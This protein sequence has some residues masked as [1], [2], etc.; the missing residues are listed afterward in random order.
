MTAADGGRLASA[1]ADR[2]Q[3]ERE[4]GAGGMATVYLAHDP[5]H[6]RRVAVKVLH[7]ELAAVIGTER[8][9]AEIRT[10]ATLH[11]PHILGLI[12]SGQ[13]DGI[14]YYVMPFVEGESLRDRLTREKQ[15]PIDDALRLAREVADALAYAHGRGV[16]HRDIKP[17]NILLQDGH[18][19]VAD[20]GIAL[21]IAGAGA[22]RLTQT[23]LSLGTPQYM[24]PEQAMGEKTVDARADVY[25]LGAVLYEMLT[26]EPPFAGPT[27]QAIVAKV[28]T[29]RPAA[30][31]T[32]RERVPPHVED[33]VLRSLEK[34]PADRFTSASELAAALVRGDADGTVRRSHA[35]A[36][37]DAHR[38]DRRLTIALV[39][40]CVV[41]TAAAIAGW[42]RHPQRTAL[43]AI[44]FAIPLTADGAA[45]TPVVYGPRLA[46]SPDGQR[47][48]FVGPSAVERQIYVRAL[49]DAVPRALAGT[50]GAYQLAFSP[51]GT[52]LAFVVGDLIRRIEL[53]NGRVSTVCTLPR[54]NELTDGV[55]WGDDDSLVVI[56]GRRA[57]VLR[58]AA[59]GGPPTVLRLA[60]DTTPA[61]QPVLLFWPD[62]LPGGKDALVNVNDGSVKLQLLSLRTGERTDLLPGNVFARFAAPGHLLVQNED[63]SVSAI[64][65]DL[66]T[67]R[68]TGA[69][70]VVLPTVGQTVG[71]APDFAVS[72]NGVFAF[73]PGG[74]PRRTVVAVE[75]GG[76]VS[77]LIGK[78]GPYDDAKYSPDG[79]RIVLG[80]GVGNRRDLWVYD[81]ARATKTRL[82]FESDN[83]FPVWNPDGRTIAFTSRRAGPA[84]IFI[85]S[86]DGTPAVRP[87]VNTN[88]LSFTGSF[89]A[90]GRTLY[91]RRTDPTLGFDIF[92]VGVNDT[93]N[94]QRPVLQ[95]RFN[96]S[97]PA[98]SPNGQLLA[99]VS[100]ESGRSEIYVRRI[101]G[102]EQRWLVT[103]DGGTEPLWRRDGKELFFRRGPDV[104]AVAM[105]GGATPRFGT[106]VKL[107]SGSYVGNSRTT[108]FD[109]SP[110]G[111][112]FLMIRTERADEHIEVTTDWTAL[113]QPRDGGAPR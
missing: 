75:R 82:T 87:V 4:L 32:R 6:G 86:A 34:L 113:L 29:E 54:G 105:E 30:I 41:A 36:G 85:V 72:R 90:D 77:V 31:V 39:T 51:D 35:R 97:A 17:E 13:V 112:R 18:A 12:D 49:G 98:V 44:R 28:L 78:E 62:L 50:E 27:A 61:G 42:L 19:L 37:V 109:V 93:A 94:L 63:L 111:T 107:F 24:A 52:S 22:Q 40:A 7:P 71:N 68:V 110:D 67:R 103:T 60:R 48:A 76:R 25:A 69:G 8:F 92:S 84:G 53:S 20:F 79:T 59:S 108:A 1:L 102:G 43:P 33:A 56:Q 26:G 65:F 45:Q 23:G 16:I 80:E 15:L 88:I 3:I 70:T 21:A 96:E 104:F 99:Y 89:S 47:V 106:G 91:Y 9:L 14:P 100:D 55:A 101:E 64:P 66:S 46:I 73:V 81:L 74:A 95:T 83:F 5:R 2:Y 58:V 11:H 38:G 10:T 57:G